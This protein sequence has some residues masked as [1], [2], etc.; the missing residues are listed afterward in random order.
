MNTNQFQTKNLFDFN[1]QTQLYILP[2]IPVDIISQGASA[3][4]LS[5]LAEHFWTWDLNSVMVNFWQPYECQ[6]IFTNNCNQ[7]LNCFS[8]YQI[9]NDASNSSLNDLSPIKRTRKNRLPRID[10]NLLKI[11]NLANYGREI[12]F[13]QC[14]KSARGLFHGVSRRRSRYVGVLRNREKWQVLLNEGKI[15]KYIGTYP[16]EVEAAIVNDFYSIGINGL[17]AKTNFSYSHS[18]VVAMITSY[19][20]NKCNFDPSIFA[21]EFN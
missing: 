17:L 11:L 4:N 9:N 1:Q 14:H 16:T 2:Y 18:Q 19:F 5:S 12:S 20:N 21:S 6:G 7:Q 10:E 3:T 8:P 13:K 15:K